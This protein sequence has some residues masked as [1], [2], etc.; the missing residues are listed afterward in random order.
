MAQ[1]Y[2]KVIVDDIT[3]ETLDD[4]DATPVTLVLNGVEY[5]ADLGAQSNEDFMAALEPYLSVFT[6]V[7][8]TSKRKGSRVTPSSTTSGLDNTAVR[9]WAGENGYTV[10]PRGRI[11]R[12]VIDA[13]RAAH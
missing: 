9:T 2:Q 10:S 4:A 12:E 3:G 13:Y 5:R 1:I 7:G 6:R 11:P 8:K